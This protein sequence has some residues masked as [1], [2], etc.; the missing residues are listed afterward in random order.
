ML[1]SATTQVPRRFFC[2]LGAAALSLS[3]M[4]VPAAAQ[5]TTEAVSADQAVEA[6]VPAVV[7]N[8]FRSATFGM[9][10]D[11]VRAAILA[12]FDIKDDAI[13]A[14]ENAVER[15]KI[16]TIAVPNLIVDGGTAQVSYVFG[17]KSETLIQ[18]GVT[19]SAKTDPDLT[20]KMLYDNGDVL[21]SHFMTEGYVPDTVKA[22]VALPN[23]ILL[24]RGADAENH[25]T[26]LLLQGTYTTDDSGRNTLIP[27]SLDLLYSADPDDPDIFSLPKGSF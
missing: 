22:N 6:I 23:G 12:D 9:D 20:A 3:P 13:Q 27:A 24:F 7:V 10:H 17:Y 25:A 8:G 14:G 19:W 16:L 15:T 5:S 11:A 21:R 18:V 2:T 4:I 26:L 1:H